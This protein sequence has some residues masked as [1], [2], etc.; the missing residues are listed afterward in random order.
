MTVSASDAAILSGVGLAFTALAFAL[1]AGL[2]VLA[3]RKEFRFG[4]VD[5]PAGRSGTAFRS[6]LPAECRSGCRLSS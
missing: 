4:L 6:H 3:Q 1:S 2:G 5:F